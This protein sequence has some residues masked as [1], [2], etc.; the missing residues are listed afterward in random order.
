MSKKHPN[1]YDE[2]AAECAQAIED[3]K[4]IVEGTEFLGFN[5]A[6]L[7]ARGHRN[8]KDNPFAGKVPPHWVVV[9]RRARQ[10]REAIDT[11]ASA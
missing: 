5:R 7:R 10:A 9:A 1:K 6:E 11:S 8:R 3:S 2:I 4:R